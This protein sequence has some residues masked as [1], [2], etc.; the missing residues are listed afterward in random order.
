[1]QHIPREIWIAVKKAVTELFPDR[2]FLGVKQTSGLIKPEGDAEAVAVAHA[3]HQLLE[4]LPP[5][6]LAWTMQRMH[7]SVFTG[8]TRL[9][10]ICSKVVCDLAGGVGGGVIDPIPS[11]KG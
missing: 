3:M 7:P 4:T 1:M 6:A 9:T 5:G 10:Q 8:D 11:K 2:D